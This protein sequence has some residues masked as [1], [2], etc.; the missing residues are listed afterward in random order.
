MAGARDGDDGDG[1]GDVGLEVSVLGV[2]M[3]T[4]ASDGVDL[5]GHL[6][7]VLS[8]ALPEAT[9]VDRRGGLFSEK[10]VHR[11]RV[12][13]A[14]TH[15]SISR[16]KHGPVAEKHK[17][18]RGVRL[19]SRETPVEQWLRDLAAEI[20]RLAETSATARRALERFL[21]GA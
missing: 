5:L 8:G 21:F 13:I 10:K 16:D 12:V 7:S 9:I 20:G 18:V 19:S 1:D 2:L 6:A 14:D 3:R 4:S 17:I 11:I 15:F